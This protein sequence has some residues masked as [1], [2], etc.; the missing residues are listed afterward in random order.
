MRLCGLATLVAISV[1]GVL[2]G[3]RVTEVSTTLAMIHGIWGQLCFCLACV[4]VLYVSKGWQTSSSPKSV[5]AAELLQRLCLLATIVIVIQLVLGSAL[6]HFHSDTALVLHLIWSVVVALLVGWVVLWVLGIHRS[7]DM[8]KILGWTLGLL[9]VLQLL[10]GGVT[11]IITRMGGVYSSGLT[12]AIPS[13]HVAAGALL[14]AC[15]VM[16]TLV[17][18]RSLRTA[19]VQSSDIKASPVAI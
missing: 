5:V 8:L 19:S 17:T 9:M 13:A 2:G 1:Q 10:L 11:W 6:R 14:L 18:Y 16:L 3:L 4:T 12:W 15:S 7:R